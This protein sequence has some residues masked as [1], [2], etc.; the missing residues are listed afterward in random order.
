MLPVDGENIAVV[1]LKTVGDL[2]MVSTMLE[3]VLESNCLHCG[4]ECHRVPGL[5]YLKRLPH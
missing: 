1:A 5:G 2:A 3:M 4:S